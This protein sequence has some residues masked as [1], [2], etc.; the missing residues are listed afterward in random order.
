MRTN[1]EEPKPEFRISL[2]NDANCGLEALD[3][4]RMLD[5]TLGHHVA[6][7]LRRPLGIYN[8]SISRVC[9]KISSCCKRL[10]RYFRTSTR[11]RELEREG[12]LRQEILDYLELAL[13]AA[14]EHVDDL[15][16][17]ARGFY[18]R[19]SDYKSSDTASDLARY[20]AKRKTLVSASANAIKH[21]QARIRLLSLEF[22]H[23]S[24]E[25]CL[26]GYFIE[27]VRNGVV[28]PHPILHSDTKRI[29]SVTS[30][31]WE[32]LCFLLSTSRSLH[33]FLAS[34]ANVPADGA[35]S[36]CGA[37]AKAV[38]A[39]ARLPLYSFD[40]E[41]PFVGS[42]IVITGDKKAVRALESGLYGSIT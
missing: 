8:V 22:L 17:F 6:H 13:Y 32:I 33:T 2:T 24:I 10:E 37:F 25:T 1:S 16:L 11:V 40:D 26:H 41:H 4:L 19:D 29:F 23:G 28:G 3:A 36:S 15:K 39:A 27:G 20:V 30:L 5:P 42:R 38:M 31:L 14:A 34:V 9:E 35:S 21:R 18:A 12:E 7:G